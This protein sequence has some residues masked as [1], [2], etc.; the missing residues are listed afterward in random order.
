MITLA[1]ISALAQLLRERD[2][3]IEQLEEELKSVKAAALHLRE[4]AIPAAMMELE[5][6]SVQLLSG[7]TVTIKQDVY[8][9]IPADKKAEAFD[10]LEEHQFG[11]L[12]KTQVSVAFGK[13]ELM[14]AVALEKKLRSE[15]A[16]PSFTRDVHAQTLK[17]WLRERLAAGDNVPLQLFGA[18]PVWVAK[19]QK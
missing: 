4:E 17:A 11:G 19:I 12:I 2:Q 18:R 5:L 7:E 10:W 14:A 8:A 1:E 3:R 15:G 13:G 6:T 16:D 9:S